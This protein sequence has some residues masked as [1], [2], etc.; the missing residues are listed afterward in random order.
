L[1]RSESVVGGYP[2]NPY[3]H[4]SGPLAC[5]HRAASEAVEDTQPP[6]SQGGFGMPRYQQSSVSPTAHPHRRFAALPEGGAA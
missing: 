3:T 6:I 4:R 1:W 2:R 5:Q